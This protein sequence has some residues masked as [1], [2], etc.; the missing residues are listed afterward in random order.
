MFGSLANWS[1]AIDHADCDR[2]SVCRTGRLAVVETDKGGVKTAR[3]VEEL[4]TRKGEI[5][6]TTVRD[7]V[8]KQ[9][10]NIGRAT[11]NLQVRHEE[12]THMDTIVRSR[13]QA[14]QSLGGNH[15]RSR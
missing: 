1:A 3:V 4:C 2:P 9:K 12:T 6:R 7:A 10:V 15:S 8:R 11:R 13:S 5:A 14:G